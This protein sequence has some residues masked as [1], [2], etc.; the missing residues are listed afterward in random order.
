MSSSRALTIGLIVAIVLVRAWFNGH[1]GSGA[2][3][4]LGP[5]R[6]LGEA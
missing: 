3:T 1:L 5:T 6:M 4:L 2:A